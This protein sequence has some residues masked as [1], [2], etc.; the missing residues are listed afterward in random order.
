MTYTL[1]Q[2]QSLIMYGY[3]SACINV[4]HSPRVETCCELHTWFHMPLHEMEFVYTRLAL[5]MNYH[6]HI[7]AHVSGMLFSHYND[8]IMSPMAFQI[9]SLTIVYSIVYS[10][11]DQRKYQSFA[12]LAFVRG[13]HR[14]PVNFPH[15]GLVTGKMFPFDDVTMQKWFIVY[16]TKITRWKALT[17]INGYPMITRDGP[18]RNAYVYIVSWNE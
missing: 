18:S 11:A 6:N 9:T 15:K 12:S 4:V 16:G 7:L 13:I 14:W 3:F 10:G 17:A 2:R 5:G 8:A 1:R